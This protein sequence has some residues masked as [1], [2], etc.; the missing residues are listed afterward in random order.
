MPKSY[1]DL[2]AKAI[3]AEGYSDYGVLA[4]EAYLS[5]N[6]NNLKDC[7]LNKLLSLFIK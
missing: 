6:A 1:H 7:A 3:Q 2:H 5:N 4:D